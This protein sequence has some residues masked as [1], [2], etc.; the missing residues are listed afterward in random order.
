M[1]KRWAADFEQ[2]SRQKQE[3][4]HVTWLSS[5]AGGSCPACN[6]SSIAALWQLS[7][8]SPAPVA[9]IGAPFCTYLS[10]LIIAFGRGAGQA[11][12]VPSPI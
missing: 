5:T 4:G 1:T 7:C 8:C 2:Q 11:Q 10:K 3:F 6:E 9:P 12:S